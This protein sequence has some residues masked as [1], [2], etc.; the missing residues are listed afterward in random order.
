M[1]DAEDHNSTG[2][3]SPPVL[4]GKVD[5][6]EPAWEVLADGRD[7][8]VRPKA[9]SEPDEALDGEEA[10]RMWKRAR[11]W[12]HVGVVRVCGCCGSC[13]VVNDV[14]I[15]SDIWKWQLHSSTN[16]EGP[17]RDNLIGTVSCG[18]HT[19]IRNDGRRKA[20]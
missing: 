18:E 10:S 5:V 1:G 11:A 14:I 20:L 15:Q 3:D 7:D 6:S 4:L 9:G 8:V 13:D 12:A 17:T 2:H 19:A 16:M